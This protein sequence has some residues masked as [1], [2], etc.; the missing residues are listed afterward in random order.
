MHLHFFLIFSRCGSLKHY[1][2][3]RSDVFKHVSHFK[4]LRP[5]VCSSESKRYDQVLKFQFTPVVVGKCQ[6]NVEFDVVG[7]VV[8]ATSKQILNISKDLV[9]YFMLNIGRESGTL[10]SWEM[11]AI[12]KNQHDGL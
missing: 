1:I 7:L 3:F 12:N 2:L 9:N 4:Y 10:Y 6:T 5:G 8:G 11:V